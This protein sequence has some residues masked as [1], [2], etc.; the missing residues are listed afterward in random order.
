VKSCKWQRRRSSTFHGLSKHE[1]YPVWSAMLQRCENPNHQDFRNYGKRGIKVCERWHSFPTFIEDI[2]QALGPRPPGSHVRLAATVRPCWRAA[3]SAY[4]LSI[5]EV[6]S[7][8]GNTI[9]E[10]LAKPYLECRHCRLQQVVLSEIQG[11]Y[12]QPLNFDPATDIH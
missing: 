8:T 10:I 11:P 6:G 5:P 1:L 12:H 9:R 3:S 2:L 4:F 7:A